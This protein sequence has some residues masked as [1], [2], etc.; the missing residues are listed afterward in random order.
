MS[1]NIKKRS[2]ALISPFLLVIKQKVSDTNCREMLYV[3]YYRMTNKKR[4][5]Y[6]NYIFMTFDR[7]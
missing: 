1:I 3:T 4:N 6:E 5:N 2:F 7:E